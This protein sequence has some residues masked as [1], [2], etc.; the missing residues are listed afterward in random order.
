[1]PC[2]A[3]LTP[4]Q[5]PHNLERRDLTQFHH[6]R[7]ELKAAPDAEAPSLSGI[8]VGAVG[9]ATAAHLRSLASASASSSPAPD[10]KGKGK[11]RANTTAAATTDASGRQIALAP[12]SAATRAAAKKKAEP[13]NA[14][15]Y[16]TG[17]M[18]ASLTSTAA[19]PVTQTDRALIDEE[20]FMFESVSES[21]VKVRRSLALSGRTEWI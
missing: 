2:R 1:M 13:Y 14:A 20:E 21:H 6:I 9:G 18:A 19:A 10:P 8:N 12:E 11:A 3:S 5:D 15:H 17:R 16:S 7:H 4:P